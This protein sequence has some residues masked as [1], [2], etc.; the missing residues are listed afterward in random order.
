MQKIPDIEVM[1]LCTMSHCHISQSLR[2]WEL[3]TEPKYPV[4]VFARKLCRMEMSILKR[5]RNTQADIL[6]ENLT[7][8]HTNKTEESRIVKTDTAEA[9]RQGQ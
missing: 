5:D 6:Q 9:V 8:V 7:M 2:L 1:V 3:L 4:S